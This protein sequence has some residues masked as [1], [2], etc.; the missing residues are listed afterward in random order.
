VDQ[1]RV[2]QTAIVM[3]NDKIFFNMSPLPFFDIFDVSSPRIVILDIMAPNIL[4]DD[5]SY[6][7]LRS[8]VEERQGTRL[9]SA[10]IVNGAKC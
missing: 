3:G 5:K 8:F 1:A 2:A 7:K 9:M 10:K 6:P 4:R